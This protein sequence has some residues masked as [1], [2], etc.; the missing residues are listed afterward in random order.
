M[1]QD[2]PED[3]ANFEK[4]YNFTERI[5]QETLLYRNCERAIATTP[6]QLD[7]IVGDYGAPAE[8][9]HMIPPG[10]DDT[11]FYPVSAATRRTIRQRLGFEGPVVMPSAGSPAT[12]ATTC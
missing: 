4:K 11:R 12:R 9:A 1:E 6:P 3:A 10:Y 5:H 2:F 8:Q 7:M